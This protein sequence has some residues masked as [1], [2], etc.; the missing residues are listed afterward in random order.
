VCDI[1]LGQDLVRIAER[2]PKHAKG[3]VVKENDER[4]AQKISDL[5]LPM[6]PRIATV[7]FEDYRNRDYQP[8][9]RGL[10]ELCHVFF[11]ER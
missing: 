5:C 6:E 4:D 10:N 8:N 1:K 2:P 11:A 7:C 3:C 9:R